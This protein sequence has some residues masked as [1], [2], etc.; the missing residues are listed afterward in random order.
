LKTN[1]KAFFTDKNNNE[2][3]SEFG[4]NFDETFYDKNEAI[5]FL[6][7]HISSSDKKLLDYFI[8]PLPLT[9]VMREMFN[10]PNR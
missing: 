2:N 4:F 1:T 5:F 10:K 8:E 3:I 7:I 9:S 6:L